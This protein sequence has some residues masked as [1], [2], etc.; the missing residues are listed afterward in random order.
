MAKITIAGNAVVITSAMKLEDI[1]TIKKYRPSALILMGGEDGKDQ[2]FAINVG[3]RGDVNK[4]GAV[5]AEET[6]NDDKL[7]T[8]TTTVSYTGNDIKD[9]VA[10]KFGVTI[11]NLNKLEAVLPAVLE[12]ITNE[13]AEI[14]NNITIAQ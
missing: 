14:I 12:E 2:V 4:Y 8:V 3:E 9:Y 13:K 11:T 10:D 5:F 6:R 7:A 1:R